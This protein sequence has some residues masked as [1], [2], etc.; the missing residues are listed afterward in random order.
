MEFK[1]VDE[2]LLEELEENLIMADVGMESSEKIIE[3][4]RN[5]IKKENITEPE[6]VKNTL[7]Q[8]ISNIF[9]G[10]DDQLKLETKPSVLLM[11]GVNWSRKNNINRKD[12]K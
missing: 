12:C 2:N 9:E 11:V 6:E 7:K 10:M 8:E 5:N 1:K 4:L 3:N